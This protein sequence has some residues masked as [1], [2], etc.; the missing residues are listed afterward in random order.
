MQAA[1]SIG[2]RAKIASQRAI[3][4]GKKKKLT[5]AYKVYENYINENFFRKNR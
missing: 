4:L 2:H 5:D 3:N 1:L